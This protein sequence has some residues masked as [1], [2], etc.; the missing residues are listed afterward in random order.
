MFNRANVSGV[1]LAFAAVLTGAPALAQID[2]SGK[3]QPRLHEDFPERIPGPELGDYVGLPVNDSARMFADSWDP[4]RL[5]LPEHQCRVHTAPYIH[6]GPL[7]MRVWEV[8]DPSTQILKEIKIYISTYEQVRTIYMDDRAVPSDLAPH[9]WMGFSKG[10]YDGDMLK[11]HTTHIKQN[12][13]RRNG[14]P[15]SDA[16]ELEE[17]FVRNG[18]MLTHISVVRDPAYLTEP[19]TK[20]ENYV[21]NPRVEGQAAWTYPCIAVVEVPREQGDVP[22]YLPGQN[23]NFDELYRRWN[24]SHEAFRGGAATMYPEWARTHQLAER[25]R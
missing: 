21:L 14:L 23:S 20:S 25:V 12:W 7:N 13:V 15:Q 1:V 6:R 18:D 11:V 19:L 2:L 16:A 24:I 5:T 10:R 3:W 8:R 17:V 22:H 4:A 9:T